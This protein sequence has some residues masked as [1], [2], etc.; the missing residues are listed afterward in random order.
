MLT[1]NVMQKKFFKGQCAENAQKEKKEEDY[2]GTT[3][4][5]CN[6]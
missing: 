1:G 6:G 3:R 2:L 4:G 5:M